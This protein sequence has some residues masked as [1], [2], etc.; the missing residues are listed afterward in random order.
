MVTLPLDAS[1]RCSYWFPSNKFVGEEESRYRMQAKADGDDTVF[2]SLPND[3]KSYMFVRLHIEDG[4][5]TGTWHETT[6]PTG[7]FKGAQYSGAGQ[8]VV[9]AET[10]GMEGQWAGAGYDHKLKEMRVYSGRWEIVPEQRAAN[11]Q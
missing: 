1:W 6:S 9:D 10:G 8:L 11:G 7:E 5:A 4:I 3:E 2:E